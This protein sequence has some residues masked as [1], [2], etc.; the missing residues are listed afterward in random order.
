VPLSKGTLG[1]ETAQL[2]GSLLVASIWQLALDLQC[3]RQ[4][5]GRVEKWRADRDEVA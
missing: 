2:V 1:P 4:R 5:L 3:V